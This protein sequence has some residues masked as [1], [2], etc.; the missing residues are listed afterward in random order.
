[1]IKYTT[2]Y[3]FEAI[4]RSGGACTSEALAPSCTTSWCRPYCIALSCAKLLLHRWQWLGLS[5]GSAATRGG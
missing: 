4:T 5:A 2:S 1:M 3:P